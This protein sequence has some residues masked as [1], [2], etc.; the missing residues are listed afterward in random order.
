MLGI[1]AAHLRYVAE[2]VKEVEVKLLAWHRA[3]KTS[4]R[5]QSALALDRLRQAR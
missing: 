4:R 5:L 2:K 1:L 3:D